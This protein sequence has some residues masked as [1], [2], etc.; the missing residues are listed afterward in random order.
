MSALIKTPIIDK[1][2]KATHVNR[3]PDESHESFSARVAALSTPLPHSNAPV[4][5]LMDKEYF[6]R[7][8]RV[9]LTHLDEGVSG[10]YDEDNPH[11]TPLA[12]VDIF[13]HR[14][15]AEALDTDEDT[16]DAIW[17]FP[18]EYSICT[19]IDARSDESGIE[20]WLMDNGTALEAA[21]NSNLI[22]GRNATAQ[23]MIPRFLEQA[24]TSDL[25]GRIKLDS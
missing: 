8:I 10:A 24:E 14:R 19:R 11:D 9:V 3:R 15:I 16:G 7:D 2:G 23:E 22:A 25:S 1:N 6:G 18:S 5:M 12:R 4:L 21:I 20:S 17:Y 13:V